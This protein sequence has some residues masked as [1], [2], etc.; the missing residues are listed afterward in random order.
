MGTATGT[1]STSDG[2]Y[3]VKL[4]GATVPST[5][6]DITSNVIMQTGSQTRSAADVFTPIAS[7]QVRFKMID[8]FGFYSDLDGIGI[9]DVSILIENS[10]GADLFSG[11][12]L[13]QSV[14]RSR[15][16]NTSEVEIVGVCGL[17]LLKQI[18]WEEDNTEDLSRHFFNLLNPINSPST[19]QIVSTFKASNQVT[20]S[21]LNIRFDS[22][23]LARGKRNRSYYDVLEEL[24]KRFNYTIFQRTGALGARW[25]VVQRSAYSAT[26]TNYLVN[27]LSYTVSSFNTSSARTLSDASLDKG[28]I[29]GR[30]SPSGNIQTAFEWPLNS[31]AILN[32]GLNEWIA[33][34]ARPRSWSTTNGTFSK[35]TDSTGVVAARSTN[36]G[37]LFQRMNVL[38]PSSSLFTIRGN[39]RY[40][41]TSATTTNAIFEVLRIKLIDPT[42]TNADQW[43]TGSISTQSSS[44]VWI[45]RGV[46]ISG[47]GLYDYFFEIPYTGNIDNPAIKNA[48]IFEIEFKA[49]RVDTQTGSTLVVSFAELVDL[50]VEITPAE[51]PFSRLT[52]SAAS[53]FI[54]NSVLEAFNLSDQTPYNSGGT[55]EVWNGSAWLNP[56][57]SDTASLGT[58]DSY[59]NDD[60]FRQVS[61]G[62]KYV[63][64]KILPPGFSS[65]SFRDAYSYDGRTWV[66]VFLKTNWSQ[67]SAEMQIVELRTDAPSAATQ[68]FLINQ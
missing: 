42:G 1:F 66:P 4:I 14:E 40:N 52:T 19:L 27:L 12:V 35:A 47:A 36:E 31:P 33:S 13:A 6:F 63:K 30:L 57:Y 60:R 39:V 28:I 38:K 41:V 46:A 53:S 7:T 10:S 56:T 29:E 55:I 59:Y 11:Y 17:S 58:L 67:Q 54:G 21:P 23:Y 8:S 9:K 62:L 43:L 68:Q 24:C 51:I 50:T 61:R 5:T 49:S 48:W 3:T 32:S 45:K 18:A 37:T 64:C 20:A 15:Y 22:R 44:A 16:W 2:D 26:V 65:P 34:G 25:F